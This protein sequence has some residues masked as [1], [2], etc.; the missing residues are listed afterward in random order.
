MSDEVTEFGFSYEYGMDIKSGSTWLPFR[1]PTGIGV[2]VT[3]TLA[4]SQ[5]YDD[6]G[7]ANDTKISE[8]WT[9]SLTVQQHRLADGKYLPEVEAL[10]ALTEPGVNGQ[11]AVGTFRWYDKPAEGTANPDDAYEGD[12]TVQFERGETGADGI[13]SW[14]VTLTG[15]GRR[16]KIANPWEGW[17]VTP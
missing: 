5:T 13:G 1:F 2:P 15:K 4:A 8:S 7:S 14:N 17:T 10:K 12:A 16:R 9:A 6:L 3:P 11:A